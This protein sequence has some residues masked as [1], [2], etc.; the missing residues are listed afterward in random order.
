MSFISLRLQIQTRS[1]LLPFEPISGCV[2]RN[3]LEEGGRGELRDFGF[4]SVS[5]PQ[6]QQ[7]RCWPWLV[8]F[9][10][11][12]IFVVYFLILRSLILLIQYTRVSILLQYIFSDCQ[13]SAG[14]QR[15]RSIS[16]TAQS[17]PFLFCYPFAPIAISFSPNVQYGLLIHY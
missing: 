11:T 8:V 13:F 9:F 2:W 6:L 12:C 3:M 5:V 15:W 1:T 10:F 16:W 7:H 4:V 14:A 17:F